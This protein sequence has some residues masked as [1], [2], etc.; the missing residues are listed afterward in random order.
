MKSRK[1]MRCSFGY[2]LFARTTTDLLVCLTNLCSV[3]LITMGE[4]EET[5]M[6]F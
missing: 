2:L 3:Q 1:G 4:L 5:T 6:T